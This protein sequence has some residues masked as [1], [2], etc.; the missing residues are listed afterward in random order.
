[1]RR[2]VR[3][4]EAALAIAAALALTAC[5]AT[6]GDTKPTPTPSATPL[7]S[8]DEEALAAAE[9]AYAA[10]QETEDEILASGGASG[11]RI[12]NFAVREALDA[13]RTGF[14]EYQTKGYR[15]IGMITFDSMTL[16][17]YD[18]ESRT[19]TDVV[20]AYICLDFSNQDV[21]DANGQSIVVSNRSVRQTFQ[22]SFDVDA[23]PPN[24]KPRL[25]LASRD[26]W[27]GDGVC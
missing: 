2:Y 7:F 6:P 22:V 17:Q 1:M 19:T 27:D 15:S 3:R 13:A 8:S 5:V 18:K 12:E 26:P 10:Y 25:L 16:Q 20:T 21:I 24:P 9:E 4:A 23:V 14:A 11:D